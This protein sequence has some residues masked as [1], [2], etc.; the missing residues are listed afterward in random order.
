MDRARDTTRLWRD[1][2]SS[3]VSGVGAV[4]RL[5]DSGAG[6]AKDLLKDLRRG[7]SEGRVRYPMLQGPKVSAVW[8]RIMANPGGAKVARISIIS[9]AVDVQVRRATENLRVTDARDLELGDAKPEIQSTRHA[10]VTAASIGG[11]SG[12]TGTSAA[13]DPVLWFFGTHGCSHCEKVNQ[14]VHISRACNHCQLDVS[15]RA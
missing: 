15:S 11:P 4:S 2:A 6:D 13:L 12:I 5:V 8:V 14:R 10:A 1:I 9:V 7:D 3:L